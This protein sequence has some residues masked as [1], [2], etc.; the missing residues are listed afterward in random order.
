LRTKVPTESEASEKWGDSLKEAIPTGVY[1]TLWNWVETS[2]VHNLP[3]HEMQNVLYLEERVLLGKAKG[4]ESQPHPSFQNKSVIIPKAFVAVLPE[5]RYWVADDETFAVIAPGNKLIWDISMQYHLPNASHSVFKQNHLPRATYTAENVAVLS[6]IWDSNYYHWLGE[7]LA[8]IHL[9]DRSG[10]E[11]DKYLINGKGSAAFQAETLSLLDIPKHKIIK[12][13]K[14]MHLK[15]KRLIVPSL[16]PFSL[17][18]FIPHSLAKWA[19]QYLRAELMGR[20]RPTRVE[21]FERIY[22]SRGDA[23]HRTVTNEA[24]VEELLKACGFK[25]VMTGQMSVADQIRTFA[26]AEIVVAPHGAGLANLMFCRPG[27][28]VLEL[29][30]PNYVNPLYW[31]MSNHIGLDYGYLIGQGQ[32]API[33]SGIGYVGY[34]DEPITVD[35]VAFAHMLKL[36][37]VRT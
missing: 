4:A 7:V 24:R 27:V 15:A 35:L 5:G 36:L 10:I 6:F 34:R 32:K 31:Y 13:V 28:R 17:L 23:R 3:D 19:I 1:N 14:G 21:G 25:T 2:R 11:I 37:D 20:V 8:R 30:A 29:F 33:S 9:L 16:V 26:S 12:S 18:P 22:V